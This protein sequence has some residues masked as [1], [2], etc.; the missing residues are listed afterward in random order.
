MS[1]SAQVNANLSKWSFVTHKALEAEVDRHIK[2]S[3]EF[4]KANHRWTD[5]T[6]AATGAL[7]SQTE[8][9]LAQITSTIYGGIDTNLYLDADAYFF[10]G[11]YKIIERARSNNMAHLWARVGAIM[12][13]VGGWARWNR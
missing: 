12:K 3:V 2:K 5:R 1:G 9:N 8:A 7:D 13:G 6:G 10:H 4:A 11:K